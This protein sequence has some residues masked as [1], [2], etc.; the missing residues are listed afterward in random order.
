MGRM[1]RIRPEGGRL[2]RVES[3]AE[4]ADVEGQRLGDLLQVVDAVVWEADAETSRFTFV[5]PR[6]EDMFGYSVQ[7]CMSE[8]DF[9]INHA[10]PDD[11]DHVVAICHSA[12]VAGRDHQL[13]YRVVAADGRSLWVHDTCRVVRDAAGRPTLLRGVLVDITAR[14][15]TAEAQARLVG[16]LTRAQEQMAALLEIAK[17]ISGTVDRDVILDRVQRRT[18]A[19]LP[20]DRVVT[21]YWDPG[22]RVFRDIARYGVPTALV[23]DALAL[24]FHL[25]DPIANRLAEGEAVVI[26]DPATQQLVP[27]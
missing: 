3:S 19:L 12:A 27:A 21:F 4:L 23:P 7:Q 5:S 24:D 11:R 18:A 16:E 13:E 26:N 1:G 15:A 17:D 25:D 10:H 14:K 8:P 20:C 9:W 2:I 22:T 6:V